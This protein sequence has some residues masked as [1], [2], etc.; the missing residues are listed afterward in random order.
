MS[1]MT[2]VANH[3]V[4]GL[5]T[6]GVVWWGIWCSLEA[7]LSRCKRYEDRGYRAG[8]AEV[9]AYSKRVTSA[10]QGFACETNL[11]CEAFIH[12][13]IDEILKATDFAILHGPW[14]PFTIKRV[15]REV[16][17]DGTLPIPGDL[18]HSIPPGLYIYSR[19]GDAL[20]IN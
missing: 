2:D 16:L 1:I 6:G 11:E 12:L 15:P 3:V 18:K 9:S 4:A 7:S 5:L 8:Q 14:E 17:T 19:N 10:G 20:K 13:T